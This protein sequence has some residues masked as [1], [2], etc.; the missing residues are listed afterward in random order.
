MLA[1]LL[2]TREPREGAAGSTSADRF[3]FQL[4]WA[5]CRLLHLYRSN[6]D[7]LVLFD[8]HDDVVVCDSESTPQQ[9]Q[10]VQVK[11]RK[12]GNW[13][14]ARL[15][16]RD[17]QV[18]GDGL[19]FI[20]K[21]YN[22]RIVFGD[23]AKTLTFLSNAPFKLSSTSSGTTVELNRIEVTDLSD[24]VLSEI[25]EQLQA[26]HQLTEPPDLAEL[27]IF[28]VA[29]V[30]LDRHEEQAKG[31]LADFL[32][33][34]KP[35][36]A[37]RIPLIFNAIKGEIRRRN[38]YSK[39][40]RDFPALVQEKG[41]GRSEFHQMIERVCSTADPDTRWR[42]IETLLDR[43]SLDYM[44]IRALRAEYIR[45]DAALLDPNDLA[46]QS[47]YAEIK[48][49]HNT[50]PPDLEGDLWDVVNT[51][52]ERYRRSAEHDHLYEENFLCALIL[53]A[54]NS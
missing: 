38:N 18:Q 29:D 4:N 11:T 46:L 21:L 40:P 13:T 20:G 44:K 43:S 27:L 6:S 54:M 9:A 14:R 34:I 49:L 35:G 7:F 33:E 37:F 45:V 26:E 22:H 5:F 1:D 19:S 39:Q 31:R 3:E 50:L 51:V 2:C 52:C 23:Y 10:F 53:H 28:E 36:R 41:I 25:A 15:L 17:S 47:A 24:D 16:K 12:S 32:E 8:Y 48:S 30:H 42:H